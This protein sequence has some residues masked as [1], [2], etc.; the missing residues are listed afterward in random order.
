MISNYLAAILMLFAAYIGL[1]RPFWYWLSQP[2]LSQMQ[3][4]IEHFWLW[5]IA[6]AIAMI[7]TFLSKQ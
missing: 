2:D 5:L 6:M 1:V 4:F 7:T 3:V